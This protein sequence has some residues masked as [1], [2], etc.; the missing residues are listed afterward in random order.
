MGAWGTR[1]LATTSPK[2][3]DKVIVQISTDCRCCLI[4]RVSPAPWQLTQAPQQTSVVPG[5]QSLSASGTWASQSIPP[6]IVLSAPQKKELRERDV[7]GTVTLIRGTSSRQ[8]AEWRQIG[9]RSDYD[10]VNT[11]VLVCFS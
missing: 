3:H 4:Y 11:G 10:E 8:L 9:R 6:Q 1:S 7:Y 5:C 2:V